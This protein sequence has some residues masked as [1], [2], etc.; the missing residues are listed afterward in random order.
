MSGGTQVRSDSLP[1]VEQVT[2]TVVKW[3]AEVLEDPNVRAEDN[4][5]DLGGHSMLAL[6]LNKNASDEFGTEFDMRILFEGTLREAA[7][8]LV[9]AKDN[10]NG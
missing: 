7:A 1:D 8:D 10:Q 3:V 6:E 9:S 5:L 4:F 2:Q